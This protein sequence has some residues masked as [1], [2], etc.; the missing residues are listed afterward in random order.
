MVIDADTKEPITGA[1]V[2][3]NRTTIGG[4]TDISGKYELNTTTILYT[5]LIISCIGYEKVVVEKPFEFLPDTIFLKEKSIL[6]DEVSVSVKAKSVFSEKKKMQ[7]FREQLFGVTFPQR[8]CRILNEKDVR[9][10]YDPEANKL[11]GYANVPLKIENYYLG[12]DILFELIE[13]TIEFKEKKSL[14]PENVGSVSIIGFASFKEKSKLTPQIKNLRLKIYN[15]SK[16]RFFKSLAQK[17]IGQKN[18]YIL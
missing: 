4:V 17:E 2:Y 3:L 8:S 15:V 13:F 14:N 12:Y 5:Q 18:Q 16:N 6:M 7:A 9:L 10:L 1:S 11:H